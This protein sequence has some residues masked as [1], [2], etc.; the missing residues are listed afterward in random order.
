MEMTFQQ[1]A[2]RILQHPEGDFTPSPPPR[3]LDNITDDN[4]MVAW[5][6]V[7]AAAAA[8]EAAPSGVKQQTALAWLLADARGAK[9]ALGKEVATKAG[10]RLATH[11]DR[12]S[13]AAAKATSIAAADRE[14]VSEAARSDPALRA[15]LRSDLAGIDRVEEAVRQK[16]IDEVYRN[17]TE[18]EELLQTG[19][20]HGVHADTTECLRAPFHLDPILPPVAMPPDL[21]AALGPEGCLALTAHRSEVGFGFVHG[22]DW[23]TIGLPGFTTQLMYELEREKAALAR[24]K[25]ARDED[26]DAHCDEVQ[27]EWTR[28]ANERSEWEWEQDALHARIAALEGEQ[29]QA[30]GREEALHEVIRI[31]RWGPGGGE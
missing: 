11:A 7:V 2:R 14:R 29:R 16:R 5:D 17:F 27:A 24:E 23:W 18:F 19:G 8:M 4:L 20:G 25:H 15:K 9:R 28:H 6:A 30:Q 12:V 1:L 26:N 31:C 10:K 13:K 21:A 3:L 22:D